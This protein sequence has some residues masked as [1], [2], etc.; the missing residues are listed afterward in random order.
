MPFGFDFGSQPA[1]VVQAV[2]LARDPWLVELAVAIA[3]SRVLASCPGCMSFARV[4]ASYAR[5]VM[6]GP[7]RPRV[8][9]NIACQ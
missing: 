7:L 3:Y 4:L 6:R 5:L 9:F 2:A 1:A 8:Q